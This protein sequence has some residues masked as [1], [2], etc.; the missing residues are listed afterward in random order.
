[1]CDNHNG[2]SLTV[3]EL[4][5]TA[6]D[7][8]AQEHGATALDPTAQE[9]VG[10]MSEQGASLTFP[11]PIKANIPTEMASMHVNISDSQWVYHCQAEGCAEGTSSSHATI[12]THVCCAHLGMKLLCPFCLVTF[13][14]SDT[15]KWHGMWAH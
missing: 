3:Q 6:S 9:F 15:L 13:L 10:G 5:A 4:E 2:L 11:N 12:Y 1:M 8:S 14:N 7:L